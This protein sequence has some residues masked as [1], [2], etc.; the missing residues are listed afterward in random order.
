MSDTMSLAGDF[1]AQTEDDWRR[2]VAGVLNKGRPEDK[3]LSPEEA[4]AKLRTG[5]PGGLSIEP[6]YVRPES[7][8]ALGLPGEM[9]FTRGR[10][11]RSPTLPWDVRQLHDDPD[12]AATRAAIMD[13]LEHGVTSVWLHV[14]ADGL[15]VGDVA[16]ALGGVDLAIAPAVVSSWDDQPGAAAALLAVLSE[17][18][19]AVVQGNL[20]L[21]P[22]GAA[23]R[24]G[25]A[26]DLSGLAKGVADV[27]DFPKVRAI[28]VDA[29]PYYDAGADGVDEISYA[30]ATGV[31]YLRRLESDGVGPEKAF[32]QIDFRVSATADQ[33]LTIAKLR[34]LRRVWARVGEVVG[35]PADARGAYTH[36][37]TALRM[38][39]RDD[40]WTNVL[41]STIAAFGASAGGADAITVLPY[42]T[43]AGLPE[44]FSRRLARN[45]Q[46]ILAD[47][48]NVGR[49]TDPAGGAWYVED[50]TDEV[51]EKAWAA[52]QEIESAG[53]MAQ[54]LADGVVAQRISDDRDAEAGQLASRRHP[55]TGVSMFPLA[56]EQPVQR[57]KRT[58][59]ATSDKALVPHRDS[60]VFEALRDR[61]AAFATATGAA[62]TVGLAAL[63]TRRDFGAR[64]TFVQNLLGVAGI[65]TV[66]QEGDDSAA[67]AAAASPDTVVIACSPKGY[68]K[69]AADAVAALRAAGVG[70]VLVAGRAKELGETTVDG[71][72]YDGMDIVAFLGGLL[73]RLGAP[74]EGASR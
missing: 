48:S 6:L 72:I 51:A 63:G 34:A 52:F 18:D 45:T 56:A 37:V 54:A 43:V 22:L 60:L 42:D 35:V 38:F 39:T 31:A 32:G 5:I 24:T 9:P 21:D 33:F 40:P 29:R 49:V 13:D 58:A 23:A 14:G 66:T 20:G 12:T 55:I 67:K 36:A 62:P 17:A 15:A 41:R 2:L 69:Y 64:E 30:V 10:A 27:A 68:G 8:R 73:D 70:Q 11:L 4:E 1:P 3:H 46:I 71:A 61:S 57:R 53:G 19:W 25:E 50:L 47:E 59:L 16:I 65:G 7:P 74:A 44:R 28:T 26:A